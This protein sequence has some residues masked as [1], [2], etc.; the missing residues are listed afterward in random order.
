MKNGKNKK[1]I[2]KMKQNIKKVVEGL[3]REEPKC[4]NN[5]NWLI[6]RTLQ[7]LGFRVWIDYRDL[8][9]MPSIDS[10]P[11]TKRHI[12]HDE[13]KYNEPFIPEPGVT[14]EKPE[15]NHNLQKEIVKGQA[16]NQPPA[17]N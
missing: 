6:I 4:R 15:T 14:F 17:N 10:I 5:N 3:L 8:K 16:G 2:L 1:V 7:E 13:N 11:R 9:D 12:Q